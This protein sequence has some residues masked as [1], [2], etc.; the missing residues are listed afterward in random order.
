AELAFASLHLLLS[1]ARDHLDRL[2]GPQRI[3]LSG[4]LGLG[5]A[6]PGDRFLIGLAVLSLLSELAE[7][8][9]LVVLLDDVQWLDRASAAVLQFAAR[10]LEGEGVA[11]LFAARDGGH[12]FAAP[13]L[14]VMRLGGLDGEASAALLAEH[15]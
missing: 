6:E 15:G 10:R 2:P 7:E 3:A 4:A 14:E 13:G 9:P 11:M 5:P 8:R 12:T 1:P